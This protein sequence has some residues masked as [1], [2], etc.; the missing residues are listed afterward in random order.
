MEI[1][2]SCSGDRRVINDGKCPGYRPRRS[3]WLRHVADMVR[4]LDSFGREHG[5]FPEIAAELEQFDSASI[6]PSPYR[7]NGQSLH[8]RVVLLANANGPYSGS[9]GDA[10]GVLFYAVS[11]D[12]KD[13]WLTETQL[14]RPVGGH[15]QFVQILHEDGFST[16][17]HRQVSAKWPAE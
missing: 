9:V 17:F 3:R 11:N 7:K 12:Y 8:H 4:T 14:D 1:V 16:F 13:V 5:R 2:A 15:A 6:G 10:P